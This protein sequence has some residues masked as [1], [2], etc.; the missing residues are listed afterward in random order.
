M[1][2][3]INALSATAGG[4]ITYIRNVVPKLGERDDLHATVLAAAGLR[5][6]IPEFR[7]VEWLECRF[8]SGAAGRFWS[9]QFR[10][11]GLVTST[12][13][14]VLISA[15]N[16]ALRKSPVPQILLSRNSLYTSADFSR[17]L[18]CRRDY[19]MWMDTKLKGELAK[20]S[21]RWADTTVAPSRAFADELAKWTGKPVHAIHHGFDR[22]TFVDEAEPLPVDA[23]KKL[24]S[25]GKALKLLYVSH[26]NYYR[27]FETLIRA[28]P[29]IR[30]RI[31]P[32][33]V[34]LL[35]TCE[36]RSD[37]NPGSYRA[38]AVAALVR[39]L[40]IA[41]DVVQLGTIPYPALANLYKASDLYVTAA[42][43]E[44]FSHPLVE[45]MSCGLPITASNIA[46]HREICGN[47]AVYFPRFSV[48]MLADKVVGVA[49]APDRLNE[50]TQ[51][52]I[53]RSQD[54]SWSEHVDE[55]IRLAKQ[56]LIGRRDIR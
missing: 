22:R 56:L 29:L 52:G 21:V 55:L 51:A 44:T 5:P 40:G 6:Q 33:G 7:N 11:P 53:A 8:P 16:F 2:V 23:H 36:L 24:A 50:L 31:A 32:R 14:D 12:G 45:A 10:L 27:N 4:G 35:L 39:Q 28:L 13:A 38:E 43:S 34:K 3:F 17:D 19:R 46:V 9:E 42:Y 47:A 1:R 18:L 15:G 30:E 54:F 48:E 37:A 49:C 20:A 41:G 26:Y 25:A